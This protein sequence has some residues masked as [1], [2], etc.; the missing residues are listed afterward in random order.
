[1]SHIFETVRIAAVEKVTDENLLRDIAKSDSISHGV[2]KYAI[3]K[4]TDSEALAEIARNSKN[5]LVRKYAIENPHFLDQ[6]VLL[7]IVKNNAN[8]SLGEGAV[9]LKK[10]F[11][12][13]ALVDIAR[14]GKAGSLRLAAAEKVMDE[15]FTR[16]ILVDIAKNDKSMYMRAAAVKHVL[17]TDQTLLVDIALN[18]HWGEARQNAVE[19]LK[20]PVILEKIAENDMEWQVRLAA[21]KKLTDPLVLARLAKTDTHYEIV[22][23]AITMLDSMKLLEDVALTALKGSARAVAAERLSMTRRSYLKWPLFLC[24]PGVRLIDFDGGK[25]DGYEKSERF[26][27]PGKHTVSVMFEKESVPVLALGNWTI[28]SLPIRAVISS[29]GKI[30]EFE[31]NAEEGVLYWI[32]SD[33]Q[34]IRASKKAYSDETFK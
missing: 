26:V 14:N 11:D 32:E 3:E 18:D 17:L 19:K 25:V 1:M 9:A 21:V 28:A 34:V 23:F 7:E 10:I 24:D 2:R 29:Q 15:A 22:R 33:S 8:D 13:T 12:K 31:F 4:L 6:L 16:S 30:F 27:S 20:D 5:T